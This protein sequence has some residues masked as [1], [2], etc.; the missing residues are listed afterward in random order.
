[1]PTYTRTGHL[2]QFVPATL[3]LAGAT[4]N[5]F[6]NWDNFYGNSLEDLYIFGAPAG[7]SNPGRAAQEI[8]ATGLLGNE[9]PISFNILVGDV[10][11]IH[12]TPLDSTIGDWTPDIVIYDNP[13]DFNIATGA[14]TNNTVLGYALGWPQ[15][16]AAPPPPYIMIWTVPVDFTACYISVLAHW[17]LDPAYFNYL[18]TISKGAPDAGIGSRYFVD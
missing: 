3:G 7:L 5:Q 2:E 12:V 13:N 9:Y 10:V 17:A 4:P 15:P 11:T 18:I 1:M 14:N 16:P 8:P 6:E